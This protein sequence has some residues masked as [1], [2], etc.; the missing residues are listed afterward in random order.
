MK[1][2]NFLK[3]GAIA[4]GGMSA[5]P[6]LAHYISS[7]QHDVDALREYQSEIERNL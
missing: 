5:N 7:E 2:R 1:R 6:A 4:V 3:A